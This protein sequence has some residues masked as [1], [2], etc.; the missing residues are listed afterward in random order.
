[1]DATV[2]ISIC[3]LVLIAYAFDLTS[4]HT[5]IP[6]VILLLLLGWGVQQLSTAFHINLPGIKSLLP[7]LGSIGL[8]LI[9]LEAGLDLELNKTKKVLIANSAMSAI[10]PLIFLMIILGL[11]F[12]Y[13]GETSLINGFVNAMPLCV[14]SSAIA[15]PSVQNLDKTQK[16]FVIYESSYSDIFGVII[17]NF[18]IA[19]EV[20]NLIGVGNFLL[21]I[22][23]ILLISLVAS[24][25]LA[26]LIKRIDHHVKFIPIIMMM[27]LVYDIS[28]IFHLP[29]L[30]FVMIFGLLLNNLDELKRF[31]FIQNLEVE[32]LDKEV[33]RFREIVTEITFLVRTVFFLLFGYTI[34]TTD[35]F[36]PNGLLIASG[37]IVLIFTIRFVY[38]KTSGMS[39]Q[40]Q[41]LFIAPRGLI[42]IL[43]FISIPDAKKIPFVNESLMI[44][45]VLISAIVMMIGLMF[46]NQIIEMLNKK[47]SENDK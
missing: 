15:I 3:I 33:Y 36:N 21:Q 44:Q 9:V 26:F 13:Y 5:K 4:K 8:I 6:T 22:I 35:L 38:M 24:V 32:K 34:N 2:I 19:N 43:L 29:A 28:K 17:F 42:T 12:S 7:A 27:I 18:F 30:I 40:M 10:I 39:K 41:F 46:N 1:M 25:G 45:V 11:L 20:I 23:I 16:E 47:S 14:I 37:I 31:K